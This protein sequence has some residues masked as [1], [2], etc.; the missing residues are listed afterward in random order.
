MI[1]WDISL[2][3]IQGSI[4]PEQRKIG[5]NVVVQSVTKESLA[6]WRQ[7]VTF[8]IDSSLTSLKFYSL[9]EGAIS[10]D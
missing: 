6:L 8:K 5:L 3:N 7:Q 4:G 1:F 10:L 2:Q 9:L